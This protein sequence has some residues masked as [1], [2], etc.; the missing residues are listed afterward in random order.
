MKAVLEKKEN[1]KVFFNFELEVEKFEKAMQQAYLKNRSRFNIP[2]FRK[3]KVPRKIIEMNYGEEIFYEDAINLILPEAYEDAVKELELEPVD[4][5]DIDIEDIEKGKSILVKVEVDVKPEFKLG[6]Y[7]SIELE[8]I[9]YNVTDEMVEHELEHVRDENARLLDA[10]DREVKDKDILTIDF[11]GF[12]DEEQFPGGTAEGF[13]LT[14]GSN[15]FIPGFEEQLIGK[16]KDEEVE[17]KVT[18]PEEYHEETL[19]GKEAIFKVVIHDIKEKELPELDDE[20]AKDVSEFDTLEEYKADIRERLEKD[21]K[22][23][24]KVETEN[25]VIEKALEISEVDIPNGMVESQIDDEMRQFDYR[26]RSQ[27]LDLE[28]Y[29]E[30]TGSNP[31]DL[32]EQLKPS[33]LNRVKV[34]LLLETIVKA[35]GIEVTEEEL[36]KE[37]EDLAEQYAAEDKEEFIEDMKKGNLNFIKTGIANGKA[38]KLLVESAKFN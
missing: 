28:K 35:E 18:F 6:D 14:I 20:F 36:E 37:L 30:F 33:A 26:L 15:M 10:S 13:E 32:R 1:N 38:V 7:K 3:G 12:I 17:V 25:R 31:E 24:E 5:P 8:K 19:A 22:E 2:G 23:Q 11:A 34:D 16:K 27:G 4:R 9:E 21:L 29:L